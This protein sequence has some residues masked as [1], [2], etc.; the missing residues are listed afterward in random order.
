MS[1]FGVLSSLSSELPR[2]VP[3]SLPGE[4]RWSFSHASHLGQV[5]EKNS[6]EN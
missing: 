3:V 4:G 6:S 2:M 1:C 5:E